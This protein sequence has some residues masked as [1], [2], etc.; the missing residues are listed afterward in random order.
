[1]RLVFMQKTKEGDGNPERRR[2]A[3]ARAGSDVLFRPEKIGN[4][5]VHTVR[6]NGFDGVLVALVAEFVENRNTIIAVLLA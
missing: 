4:G 1:M 5:F 6:I 2:S 3:F